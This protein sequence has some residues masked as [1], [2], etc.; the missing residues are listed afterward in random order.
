ML[1][2]AGLVA[3]NLL[4]RCCRGRRQGRYAAARGRRRLPA[5]EP[6]RRGADSSVRIDLADLHLLPEP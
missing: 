6:Q 4:A 5:P 2:E 3:G 1:L